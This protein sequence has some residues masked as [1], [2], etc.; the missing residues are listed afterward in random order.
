M[1]FKADQRLAG[2]LLQ[3]NVFLL[4]LEPAMGG[5]QLQFAL[6]QHRALDMG[7]FWVM[8][9][10]AHIGFM[11]QQAVD[12]LANWLA[13][14]VARHVLEASTQCSNA[15]GQQLVGQRRRAQRAQGRRMMVF[16]AAGKALQRLQGFIQSSD[17]CLQFQGFPG[18]LQTPAH[19]GEQHEAQL[20]LSVLE[21]GVYFAHGELQPLGGG[22]EVAGLQDGLNHFDMT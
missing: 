6:G 17:L 11:Q 9:A 15:L 19:A 14:Q 20:L 3:R 1:A 22:A 21:S 18:G 5:Q 4:G 10:Q 16:Q 2:Q 13:R 8:Q 7:M 12:D